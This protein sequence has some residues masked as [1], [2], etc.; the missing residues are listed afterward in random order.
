ML[1]QII[2]QIYC[3]EIV[4]LKFMTQCVDFIYNLL[5]L[6]LIYYKSYQFDRYFLILF[7]LFYNCF[8]YDDFVIISYIFIYK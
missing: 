8:E 6:F 2:K 7:C 4:Y 1:N 5:S 3:A